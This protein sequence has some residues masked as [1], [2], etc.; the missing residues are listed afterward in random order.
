MYLSLYI[1]MKNYK[2]AH[3]VLKQVNYETVY[4]LY[5]FLRQYAF[6]MNDNIMQEFY[7]KLVHTVWDV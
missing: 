4:R 6:C 1:V 2:N 5:T 7:S 3:F